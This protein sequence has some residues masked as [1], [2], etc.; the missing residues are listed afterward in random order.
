M[1]YVCKGSKIIRNTSVA[2]RKKLASLSGGGN[3]DIAAKGR[4]HC[5][6]KNAERS[7]F[8][9]INGKKELFFYIMAFL[10]ETFCIFVA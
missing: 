2:L 5:D 7:H 3:N 1:K 8:G 9:K 10:S 4:G 6:E